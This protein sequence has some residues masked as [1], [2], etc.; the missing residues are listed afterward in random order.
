[1]LFRVFAIIPTKRISRDIT[2]FFLSIR[3]SLQ[4]ISHSYGSSSLFIRRKCPISLTIGPRSVTLRSSWPS[5]CNAR[6]AR[7]VQVIAPSA[8]KSK[9]SRCHRSA[10]TLKIII[11]RIWESLELQRRVR[12]NVWHHHPVAVVSLSCRGWPWFHC[13]CLSA[14]S[15]PCAVTLIF[16]CDFEA[17]ARK[18]MW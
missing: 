16:S 17:R 6:G 9:V 4:Q 11:C 15:K 1:M 14:V 3:P 7:V 2:H 10:T 8:F 18:R 12:A 13:V 5:M